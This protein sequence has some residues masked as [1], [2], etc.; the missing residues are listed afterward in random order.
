MDIIYSELAGEHYPGLSKKDKSKLDN[1]DNKVY[2]YAIPAV[3]SDFDGSSGPPDPI[4]IEGKKQ[5]KDPDGVIT[6]VSN[7]RAVYREPFH[8]FRYCESLGSTYGS[9]NIIMDVKGKQEQWHSEPASI[10][11]IDSLLIENPSKYDDTDSACAITLGFS[12]TSDFSSIKTKYGTYTEKDSVEIFIGEYHLLPNTPKNIYRWNISHDIVDSNNKRIALES[13]PQPK[14]TSI[15]PITY[16][17]GY[18][19]VPYGNRPSVMKSTGLNIRFPLYLEAGANIRW[20]S[21]APRCLSWTKI[22]DGTNMAEVLQSDVQAGHYAMATK[23]KIDFSI[24]I[25]YLKQNNIQFGKIIIWM[26]WFSVLAHNKVDDLVYPRMSIFIDN[27]DYIEFE[28]PANWKSSGSYNFT[29]EVLGSDRTTVLYSESTESDKRITSTMFPKSIK[30]GT[31]K[32][33]KDEEAILKSNI[34][35]DST[36]T[37]GK[38]VPSLG[39]DNIIFYPSNDLMQYL[40]SYSN[41]YIRINTHDGTLKNNENPNYIIR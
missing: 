13:F 24:L 19:K 35:F 11:R 6:L 39:K 31:W 34:R 8:S 2:T 5:T 25:P 28:P 4:R 15:S 37:D 20:K 12:S 38:G 36:Y 33:G 1:V 23:A 7:I 22:F 14:Q 17:T 9:H 41:I 30:Y 3:H 18:A 40:S 26:P 29:V 10:E 16:W 32:L 27:I 21:V